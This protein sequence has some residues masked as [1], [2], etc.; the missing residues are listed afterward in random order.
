M[1]R[2][3]GQHPR[4]L[5]WMMLNDRNYSFAFE[6]ANGTVL[7]TWSPSG[8]TDRAVFDQEVQMVNSLTG[9]ITRASSCEL[10]TVPIFVLDVPPKLVAQAQ[11]NKG[12][13]L[14]W[15]GDFTNSKSVSVTMG[16]RNTEKGLHTLSGQAIAQAVLA[17]GGSARAGDVP[18]GNMFIVD[19]GFLSYTS[20]PIEITAVVRRNE[21]NDNAGFKLVYESTRGF[22][23]A[24]TW[25]TVPDNKQ[26]HTVRWKI[27]DPQF[28]N[29]WGY[30]FSLASDGNEYNKYYVQSVTVTKLTE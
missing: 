29:Y 5:G 28:V 17:Y 15:G 26:W 25:Y 13:P 11:Q 2:H 23:T 9:E 19:P 22:K 14:L 8:V 20:T 12:K 21:A 7:I 3:L 6:G 1:I 10:T 30:N 24:G 16:E 4:Y 27:D 18:G